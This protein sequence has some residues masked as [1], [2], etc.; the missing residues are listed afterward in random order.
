MTKLTPIAGLFLFALFIVS[1]CA[2][3]ERI[4]VEPTFNDDGT[5]TM[6]AG[7]H[8]KAGKGKRKFFGDHYR[9]AWTTPVKIPVI[10]LS[11]IEGGLK[12]I[13]KG[14]GMQTLSL[15][16]ENEENNQFVLR[17]IDKDPSSVVPEEFQETFAVDLIQDQISAGH[18]YG[19]FA[20]P[21][22]AEAIG[23]YHTNPKYVFVGDDPALEE[24]QKIFANRL[25]LFEERPNE[26]ETDR[27]FFGSAED[28]EGTPDVV[29]KIQEDHNHVV[30]E[31]FTVR[32]RLFDTFINDWDRHD[33]QWRWAQAD[34][35][36]GKVYRPIPRDR[37]Q[38][39][40]KFD[41]ILPSMTNRKWGLRKFQKFDHEIRDIAG[42]AFNA[43]HFD[44]TFT[45][46]MTKEDWLG[47]AKEMQ[48]LLTDEVIEAAIRDMPEEVFDIDGPDII[49]KL[50]SRREKLVNTAE[51]LY[52]Y[53]AVEVTIVGSDDKEDFQVDFVNDN[54]VEVTIYR[55]S[56]DKEKRQS[57]FYQRTFHADETQEIRLF[58]LGKDDQFTFKGSGKRNILVRAIGGK[59]NDVFK[60]E[61]TGSGKKVKVYD[62]KEGNELKLASGAVDKTSKDTIANYYNRKE[63]ENDVAIPAL[64][65][66]FNPDDGLLLGGGITLI[67]HG[68]RKEP[69]ASKHTI[70]GNASL[71]AEAFNFKYN[72]DFTNAVGKWNLNLD[73]DVRYPNATYNFFGLG[74]ETPEFGVEDYV[75]GENED[76][77]DFNRVRL[78]QIN[79]YPS[80]RKQSHDEHHTI[81][82]GPHYQWTDVEETA[83]RFV[84]DAASGLTTEDFAASQYVGAKMNYQYARVNSLQMP[85]AGGVFN[86]NASWNNRIDGNQDKSFFRLG[87]ELKGYV[88]LGKI[89]VFAIRAG[90]THNFGD[91][92]FF[93]ANTLGNMDNFRGFRR[94]RYAGQTNFY[95]N[96]DLRIKLFELKNYI[97][98]T[99]VGLIIFND[100]GRV[101]VEDDT[102]DVLHHAYG[103]GVFF[104][105]FGMAVFRATYG[106]SKNDTQIS[107]GAGFLF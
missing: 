81:S 107:I 25:Y 92:E 49:G 19:A 89:S 91:F 44:R 1:S 58:G 53:L 97:L 101:W 60:D 10:Q 54:D 18:P 27:P 36:K 95:Q 30:D 11:E 55:L 83:G 37:D 63:F 38:V 100:F 69:Y 43:R 93:Q 3:P 15:R 40:Y 29:E 90:A 16:L 68:F 72:G 21:R 22:M 102:S 28:I 51:R 65:L 78:Q 73:L 50:K 94:F 39:F 7:A 12:P 84:T 96:T 66:G 104:A 26:D 42:I 20:I 23:I 17:T 71:A 13:K 86:L 67:K 61:T 74:N 2:A 35:G 70:V 24:F 32:S 80:L 77:S 99:T 34:T 106:I 105:P 14:G 88:P 64:F 57:V 48:K 4:T 103:G 52:D 33:D 8:Y 85:L 45:T 98:P 46:R 79:F 75:V 62:S 56:K 9:D 41:G 6:P 82:F 87:G 59:G 31:R 47:E 5:V 76:E